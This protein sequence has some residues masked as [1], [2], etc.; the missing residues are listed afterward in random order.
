MRLIGGACPDRAA[1]GWVN[2]LVMLHTRPL[3]GAVNEPPE[4][5]DRDAIRGQ[6]SQPGQHHFV[7]GER[8]DVGVEV[9]VP[10]L[11]GRDADGP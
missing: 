1:G 2:Q 5:D 6:H 10:L 9:D 11:L 8:F 7:K 3:K 4:S